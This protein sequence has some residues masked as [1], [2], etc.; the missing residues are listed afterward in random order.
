MK[1]TKLSHSVGTIKA[2]ILFSHAEKIVKQQWYFILLFSY[3]YLCELLGRG[4]KCEI[5]ESSIFISL[6]ASTLTLADFM[7]P[8]ISPG[9]NKTLNGAV[10][11]WGS[12]GDLP[13][14]L[15]NNLKAKHFS[16][17]TSLLSQSVST[18]VSNASQLK[19]TKIWFLRQLRK[20]FR[21]HKFTATR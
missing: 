1:P 10:W 2:T 13:R 12:P 6:L 17:E 3:Y 20:Q 7:F 11:W 16:T 5:V 19:R 14:F 9:L 18:F 15:G 4:R 21:A 8:F